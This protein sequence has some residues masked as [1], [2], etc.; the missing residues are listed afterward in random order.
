[1]GVSC[2]YIHREVQC[3]RI[4]WLLLACLLHTPCVLYTRLSPSSCL[5][6]GDR[7]ACQPSCLLQPRPGS[8]SAPAPKMAVRSHYQVSMNVAHPPIHIGCLHQQPCHLPDLLRAPHGRRLLAATPCLTLAHTSK[9]LTF[10]F[11]LWNPELH[12]GNA[13]GRNI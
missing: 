13:R 6:T 3:Y 5:H 7:P 12:K 11:L 2:S 10:P 1:M 4:G 8:C 9:E